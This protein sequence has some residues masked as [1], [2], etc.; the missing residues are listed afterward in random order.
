VMERVRV[1]WSHEGLAP[2]PP[3]SPPV[4]T[5]APAPARRFEHA[6]KPDVAVDREVVEV[7]TVAPL[8][9]PVAPVPESSGTPASR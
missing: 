9:E 8:G 3:P 2:V 1:F 6:P 5:P 4:P 7:P